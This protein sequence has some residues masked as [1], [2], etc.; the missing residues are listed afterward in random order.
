MDVTANSPEWKT[1]LGIDISKRTWDVHVRPTGQRFSTTAD[2]AGLRLLLKTLKPLETCWIVLEATGGLERRLVADLIDAGHQVA[3]VNPRQVRD[4]ARSLGRLAKTDRL[5]AEVLSLFAEKVQPRLSEKTPEKQLELDALVTRRRQL[6]QFH[7]AEQVRVEQASSKATRKS[8]LHLMEVLRKEIA[9]LD[10]AIARLI[11]TDD[12]WRQKAD[13]LKSVPGVGTQ[14]AA[15]LL[16]ELPELG[17]LNRQQ[18]SALAGLA[19]FN[20]DSGQSQGKRSIWGGRAAVRSI[21]YMAA[22]TARRCN[23][24]LKAFADRLTAAGKPFKVMMTACM[25]KLL[26]TL[27]T[28][29]A[30][31]SAWNPK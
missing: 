26:T 28:M 10:A 6:V 7:V 30:T 16:A 3:V 21:L 9:K 17:K 23:Q 15:S 24:R 22:L 18:I 25:R 19:P 29:I 13:L 2:E 1:F 27:N 31:K 4:F 12:D 8:I 14:S 5:D 11:E 20:R